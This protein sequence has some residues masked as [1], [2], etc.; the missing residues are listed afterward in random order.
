LFLN[1]GGTGL[2]GNFFEGGV[3]AGDQSANNSAMNS[4]QHTYW[5]F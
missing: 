5:G 3:W 4:N 2:L 1:S